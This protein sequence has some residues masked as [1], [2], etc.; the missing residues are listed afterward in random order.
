MEAENQLTGLQSWLDR[1]PPKRK[2]TRD[3]SEFPDHHLAAFRCMLCDE[4]WNAVYPLAADPMRMQ[5]RSCGAKD[6]EMIV[7]LKRIWKQ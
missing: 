3:I 4:V 1:I 2:R 6:S 5:C 7:Y